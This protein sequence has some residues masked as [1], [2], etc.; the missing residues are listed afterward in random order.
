MIGDANLGLLA[1]LGRLLVDGS[2]HEHVAL[3]QVMVGPDRGDQAFVLGG[4][5]ADEMAERGQAAGLIDRDPVADQVGQS[6]N[7]AAGQE[8]EAIGE[9][10]AEKAAAVAMPVAS[11][12]V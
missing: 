7:D 12:M 1:Q 6:R 3:E 4:P 10:P 9:F 5:V 8:R 11:K 2:I